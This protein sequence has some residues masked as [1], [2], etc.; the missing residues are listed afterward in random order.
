[1]TTTNKE[2]ARELFIRHSN[3]NEN[4]HL[5]LK[6]ETGALISYKRS[7]EYSQ[8]VS[9]QIISNKNRKTFSF[10][11]FDA[12][13]GISKINSSFRDFISFYNIPNIIVKGTKSKN[14][15]NDSGGVWIPINNCESQHYLDYFNEII[16]VNSYNNDIGMCTFD[17]LCIGIHG[18]SFLSSWTS[19]TCNWNTDDKIYDIREMIMN[20]LFFF[21][22]TDEVEEY[23][24][25]I[26]KKV[27]PDI[28][29]SFEKYREQEYYLKY[30]YE[31]R[32]GSPNR[33]KIN[34]YFSKC[35]SFHDDEV[36]ESMR[37]L[38]EKFKTLPAEMKIEKTGIHGLLLDH[39]IVYKLKPNN[40][41]KML[42]V[43]EERI[44][45]ECKVL[46]I[47]YDI[48]QLKINKKCTMLDTYRINAK[49]IEYWSTLDKEIQIRWIDEE[50]SKRGRPKGSTG[51]LGIIRKS[52][53]TKDEK[54]ATLGKRK[55]H[56]E[57][58]DKGSSHKPHKEHKERKDKGKITIWRLEKGNKYIDVTSS[59]KSCYLKRG[60]TVVEKIFN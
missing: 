42:V 5:I 58:N 2:K 51:E 11:Y 52:R 37:L 17:P 22:Y 13:H 10:I 23:S 44:K 38:N 40:W 15:P 41:Q 1:M 16:I 60:W 6:T 27:M 54:K 7:A 28:H 43:L 47:D 49:K 45:L 34:T 32:S 26:L 24:T 12:D 59:Q 29:S 48:K 57:R 21:G 8:S 36:R 9:K 20:A 56:K 14:K 39:N 18:K 19:C 53:K 46:D 55:K 33:N 50:L 4:P 3:E 35:K 25:D 30:L 31:I